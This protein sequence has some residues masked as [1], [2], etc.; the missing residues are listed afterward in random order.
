M[1]PH[2]VGRMGLSRKALSSATLEY[3][4]RGKRFVGLDFGG[5]IYY[6]MSDGVLMFSV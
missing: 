1:S 3:Y 6:E 5:N 2:G 4:V